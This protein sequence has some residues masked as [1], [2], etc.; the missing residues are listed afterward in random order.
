MRLCVIPIPSTRP[1][2]MLYSS[3]DLREVIEFAHLADAMGFDDLSMS[4]HIIMANK[5]ETYPFGV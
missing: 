4:E 1:D 5:P 2:G 3:D